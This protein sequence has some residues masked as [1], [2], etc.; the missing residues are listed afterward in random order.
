MSDKHKIWFQ[1]YDY[2]IIGY[3]FTTTGGAIRVEKTGEYLC[4]N[5]KA[6]FYLLGYL[7]VKSNSEAKVMAC[8]ILE[9]SIPMLPPK[10]WEYNCDTSN[11]NYLQEA[12]EMAEKWLDENCPFIENYAN[13]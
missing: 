1:K 13:K 10:R 5:S 8:V 9:S 3:D 6:K 12:I 11:E 2:P 4:N 7:S